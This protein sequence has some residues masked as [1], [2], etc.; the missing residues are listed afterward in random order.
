VFHLGEGARMC[1]PTTPVP[2]A[3]AFW[4]SNR[5]IPATV[6][7]LLPELSNLGGVLGLAPGGVLGLAP[8]GI[9]L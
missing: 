1:V 2:L 9:T 5:S 8:G 7:M 3:V 6:T 4:S